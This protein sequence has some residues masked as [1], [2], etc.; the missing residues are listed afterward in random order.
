MSEI[1]L[2]QLRSAQDL[3]RLV[4]EIGF[5]PFFRNEISGFS[6]EDCTPPELWFSAEAEGPWEW[7]GPAAQTRECIYGKLFGKKA[8]YV[9]RA[10]MPDFCNARRNGYD[11][12]V[13]YD[14]Q[15]ASY[16]DKRVY[17]FISGHGAAETGQI[18]HELNFHKGGNKGF[19]TIITRLQMQTYVII[20]D[21]VYRRD[22]NLQPYGWGISLYTTPE[23]VFGEDEVCAAYDRQPEESRARM[24][25]HVITILP[26]TPEPALL[27]LLKA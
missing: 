6:I 9:S 13:R 16:T 14:E 27:R 4:Q 26:R 11:F 22:K 2:P 15:L 3:V 12:D 21:F 1:V 24:L 18:K 8:G 20:G 19:D 25:A 17:D 7:K 10:W 5:L 23:A